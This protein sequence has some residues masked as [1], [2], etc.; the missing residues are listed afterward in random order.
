MTNR[1]TR[2]ASWLYAIPVL[3][4]AAGCLIGGIIFFFGTRGVIN[5][6]ESVSSGLNRA[7]MPGSATFDL[8]ETGRYTVY[9]E[10]TSMFEG[11]YYNTGAAW[12]PDMGCF[13]QPTGSTGEID[14][15]LATTDT[16]YTLNNNSGVSQYVFDI[17]EPGSYTLTCL[18]APGSSGGP[19]VVVAVGTD[20]VGDIFTGVGS[21]LG[22]SFGSIAICGTAWVI[23]SL[24]AVLLL[25]RHQRAKAAEAEWN[26]EY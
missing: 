5:S 2:P 8:A 21:M 25:V 3:I 16:T 9:Y 20:V 1:P 15:R 12:P 14:L 4:A 17:E 24:I 18:Y 6:V 7:V 23:A 13:M 22:G 19:N 11:Q 26:R 10:H